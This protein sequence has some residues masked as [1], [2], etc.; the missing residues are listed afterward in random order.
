MK[1][2]RYWPCWCLSKGRAG[3]I[4]QM[5][6]LAMEIGIRYVSIS[7][8][9]RF[10]WKWLPI[11]AIPRS[12]LTLTDPQQLNTGRPPRLVISCGRQGVIPALALKKRFG[13]DVFVV[14]IQDPKANPAC[15]DL[16]VVPKHDHL[17]GDN[18]YLTMGAIHHITPQRLERAKCD[19]TFSALTTGPDPLVAVLIG[20]PNGCYAFSRGDVDTLIKK[21]HRMA[22]ACSASMII[23][24]SNRTPPE[25]W[26]RLKDE[27]GDRHY[28]WNGKGNNPYLAAL[29]NATHLIVTG[30]SVSMTSEAAATGRPVFVEH[31]TETRTAVRFRRFHK[32]FQEAGITQ[33][34]EGT[35]Y[36][37]TYEPPNDTP[38]VAKIIR[39]R[40]S[41]YEHAPS[42]LAEHDSAA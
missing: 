17:R 16:V 36:E 5:S 42:R 26:H 11:G 41:D 8:H 22:S 15:F 3:M 10:P 28:V 25:I 1:G 27:F 20:G 38:Q 13:D 39:E 9:L 7:V 40:I 34:F 4:S 31:L 18:V 35:L 29:A 6:G 32:M 2:S 19:A 30:D 37:W 23:L 12:P 14:Q 24:P 21:L 33:P